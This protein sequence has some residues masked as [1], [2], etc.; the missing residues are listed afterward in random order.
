L[1]GGP[2]FIAFRDERPIVIAATDSLRRQLIEVEC[3]SKDR[4]AQSFRTIVERGAGAVF[5]SQ[6]PLFNNNAGE[7]VNL[8]AL[9]KIPAMY[10]NRGYTSRGGLVTYAHDSEDAFRTAVGLVVEILK[11][12]KPADLPIRNSTKFAFVINL[13]TARVLGLKVPPM[14][15][16]LA[17]EVIE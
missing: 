9:H 5:V 8:A 1:S 7:I 6:I 4:L 14:L 13:Q 10:P 11:G 3:P 15:L 12:A 2:R 16:A 17:D